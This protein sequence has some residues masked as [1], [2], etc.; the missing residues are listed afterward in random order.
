MRLVCEAGAAS[1][2]MH[3]T[4]TL[5]LDEV[6]DLS[7]AAQ[8]KL[9]RAI[10]EMSI[11]RVGGTGSRVVNVRVIA[12]T[13]QRLAD[14][15]ARGRF[16]L[17][18]YYRLNGVEIAV[19][20][21]SRSAPGHSGARALLP[22][23]SSSVSQADGVAGR[24]RRPRRLLV[25]R[26]RPRAAA[27]H[28]ARG[29]ACRFGSAARSRISRRACSAATRRI[30]C[31]PSAGATRCAPGA[32]ATHGSSS[33]A[34]R[35]TSAGRVASWASRITR[36]KGI[37]T[38]GRRSAGARRSPLTRVTAMASTPIKQT[39]SRMAGRRRLAAL[40]RPDGTVRAHAWCRR[41]DI[42]AWSLP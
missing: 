36:F 2:S 8:A 40:Q 25:A 15:V 37:S 7:P 38:S 34:A 21:T 31:R 26:Q 18:L 29:G 6:S 12:A 42:G 22:R 13:N 14:L 19:P 3:T 1:S 23:A 5:F 32:A 4:G 39:P 20:A 27:R 17:D 35:T 33:N 16:R 30:W 41:L 24:G 28:R 11:E 9:L 10:Q